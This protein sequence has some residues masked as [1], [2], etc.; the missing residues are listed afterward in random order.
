[1]PT[2]TTPQNLLRFNP[3]FIILILLFLSGC[4]GHRLESYDVGLTAGQT[5]FTGETET[6]SASTVNAR[7]NWHFGVS[8]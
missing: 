2:E 3:L 8:K 4:T 7:I 5:E 1:M 6:K